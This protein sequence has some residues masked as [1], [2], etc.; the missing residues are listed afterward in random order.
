MNI[1]GFITR[2]DERGNEIRR[3]PR[4][5]RGAMY[6]SPGWSHNPIFVH[7]KKDVLDRYY[8]RPSKYIV[9]DLSLIWHD[10]GT[11]EPFLPI[12]DDHDDKVCVLFDCLALLSDE[13]LLHWR[14]YNIRPQGEPSKTYLDRYV[15]GG[16][17]TESNRLEHLFR[18]RYSALS[19]LCSTNLGWNLF[20]PLDPDDEYRLQCLRIM[21]FDEQKKFDELVTNLTIVLID[22]L[23][24]PDLKILFPQKQHNQFR[25]KHTIVWL[26]HALGLHS[27]G[28]AEKHLC[29]LRKLQNLRSSST[30]HRKGCDP[31]MYQDCVTYFELNKLG[32]LQGFAGILQQAI[33][34]LEFLTRVVG[35]GE[36]VGRN[37]LP[38]LYDLNEHLHALL[39]NLFPSGTEGVFANETWIDESVPVILDA[40][41]V[42]QGA[43]DVAEK[44]VN[45]DAIRETAKDLAQMAKCESD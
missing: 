41:S 31:T 16:I 5:L 32:N 3:D 28:D 11:V 4:E 13:E 12:D 26:E 20:S 22:S 43:A 10:T 24:V 42:M 21:P 14:I 6:Y 8:E 9:G 7:F 19:Q 25:D 34:C 27:V 18:N 44:L 36:L 40:V 39:K 38:L 15:P 29:F 2:V 45:V 37:E 23:N 30:A 17:P 1:D 35:R 33:D